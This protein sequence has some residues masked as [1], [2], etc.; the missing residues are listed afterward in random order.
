MRVW[1]QAAASRLCPAPARAPAAADSAQDLAAEL[2]HYGFVHEVC[3]LTQP[4]WE[5]E[6]AECAPATPCL[7]PALQDDRTKL[8]AFL[9]STFLK[10]LG[11]QP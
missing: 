3:G 2:V 10:H 7:L 5:G 8:A 1:A 6:T 4:G 9:E 11:A